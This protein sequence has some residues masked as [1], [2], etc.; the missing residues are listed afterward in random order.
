MTP[1]FLVLASHARTAWTLSGV[2]QPIFGVT[3]CHHFYDE[4]R[5]FLEIKVIYCLSVSNLLHSPHTQAY[6]VLY[7]SPYQVGVQLKPIHH[8]S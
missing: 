3:L 7:H 5:C 1:V 2:S 6:R 8:T 4:K